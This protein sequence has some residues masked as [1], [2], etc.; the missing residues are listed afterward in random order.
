MSSLQLAPRLNRI[1]LRK[2]AEPK[3]AFIAPRLDRVALAR[4]SLW[5]SPSVTIRLSRIIHKTF[6]PTQCVNNVH[7]SQLRAA[8]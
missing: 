6:P 3:S 8:R 1:V 5:L 7:R 2:R 4:H